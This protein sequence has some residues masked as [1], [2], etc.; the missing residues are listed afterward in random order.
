MNLFIQLVAVMTNLKW[1][2]QLDNLIHRL[3]SM[4][5]PIVENTHVI[6]KLLCFNYHFKGKAVIQLI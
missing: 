2:K 6:Q 4:V 3:L 5:E 1:L